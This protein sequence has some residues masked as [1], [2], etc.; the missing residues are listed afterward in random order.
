MPRFLWCFI[1]LVIELL[2]EN[3]MV[4]VVSATDL[5]KYDNPPGLQDNVDIMFSAAA[6]RSPLAAWLMFI[7]WADIKHFLGAMLALAFGCLWDQAPYSGFGLMA[8]VVFAHCCTRILRVACFMSTVLPSPRPGCYSRRFPPVPD[9]W[10]GILWVG[11]T[12]I[13]GFGGCND[14]VFRW[15]LDCC[16]GMMLL[17]H[18]AC[19]ALSGSLLCLLCCSLHDLCRQ[20]LALRWIVHLRA[21]CMACT[22]HRPGPGPTPLSAPP[23]CCLAAATGRSGPWH[24]WP[25]RPTTLARCR[26][27]CGW[28]CSTPRS[29]MS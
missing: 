10:Q 20:H 12:K 16:S 21:C 25:C 15:G 19:S 4:W 2:W 14:L 17:S 28:R 18:G 3:V 5:R 26:G 24:R 7:R 29:G 6:E 27:S 8:R 9:T 11:L 13:R 1:A 23:A 22:L